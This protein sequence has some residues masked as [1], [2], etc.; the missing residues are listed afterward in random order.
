[1][2]R[3]HGVRSAKG[4]Q[5]GPSDTDSARL[6]RLNTRLNQANQITATASR[7]T[8]AAINVSPR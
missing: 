3:R 5:D 1:M 6:A 7:P 8:P 2:E 4:Y